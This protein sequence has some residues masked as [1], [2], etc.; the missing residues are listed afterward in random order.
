MSNI[1]KSLKLD[2]RALSTST[3]TQETDLRLKSDE[4]GSL[5]LNKE[6]EQINSLVDYSAKGCGNISIKVRGVKS[7]VQTKKHCKK[8]EIDSAEIDIENPTPAQINHIMD[9]L[10]E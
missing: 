2:L 6:D 4:N 10:K 7:T 1:T 8:I 9:L 5:S 3:N